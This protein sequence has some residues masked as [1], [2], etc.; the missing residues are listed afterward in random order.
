[1]SKNPLI[2]ISIPVYN[3][4]NY[5]E[6]ALLSAL[7][8][9]YDNLEILVIDDKG[10]DR[11]MDVVYSVISNHPRGNIVKVIEHEKNRGL[12]VT[13]NTSIDKAKGEFLIFLDSDDA[14]TKDCIDVLYSAMKETQADFVVGSICEVDINDTI[15]NNRIYVNAHYTTNNDIL[16]SQYDPEWYNTGKSSNLLSPIWNRLYNLDFLKRNKI[17]CIPGQKHEDLIFSFLLYLSANNCRI[18][19]NITYH[20]T[21]AR[22]GSDMD[23]ALRG[24]TMKL[25]KHQLGIIEFYSSYINYIKKNKPETAKY[26]LSM[27]ESRAAITKYRCFR[28]SRHDLMKELKYLTSN[29][30]LS[31]LQKNKS[32]L[33]FWFYLHA[34]KPVIPLLNYLYFKK[35]AY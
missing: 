29:I 21:I 19:P 23:E 11:S 13:R 22:P 2:T 15:L 16:H 3:V 18:I 25:I 12:G 27:I 7:N 34:P 9:T 35:T 14:L 10:T 6:R 26:I 32:S 4:E 5:V 1:M 24:F 17:R 20:Y 31:N 33:F 30:R 8:Q 28:L